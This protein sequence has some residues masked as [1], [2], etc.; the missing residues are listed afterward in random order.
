M[1]L[2]ILENRMRKLQGL[3][4]LALL[5]FLLLPATSLADRPQPPGP[6]QGQAQGQ[7]QGQAQGQD[8]DGCLVVLGGNGIVSIW[9]EGGIIGRVGSGTVTIEDLDPTD[10][11]RPKVFGWDSRIDVSRTK[12]QYVGSPDLRFRFT[13]GGPFHVTVN[14]VDIDLSVVG[15]GRAVLN[16]T[17]I[18]QEG[19]TYSADAGSLCA[20]ETKAFPDTPTKVVLGP[21]GTG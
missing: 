3:G 6:K 15:N 17:G 12:T 16:G 11:S 21:A 2:P 4:A 7:G 1:R 5:L 18:A 9:A 19:G 8:G 14:A 20:S 10:P 13:G